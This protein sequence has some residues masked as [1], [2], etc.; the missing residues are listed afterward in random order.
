MNQKGKMYDVDLKN[1]SKNKKKKTIKQNQ[2]NIN[3]NIVQ[4]NSHDENSEDDLAS[5]QDPDVISTINKSL[6][7]QSNHI[8]NS[9]I[10]A[11]LNESEP[12]DIDSGNRSILSDNG[13]KGP[14]NSSVQNNP[15]VF[16]NQGSVVLSPNQS[17]Q[18]QQQKQQIFQEN[19]D[20]KQIQV[21]AYL[22]ESRD[23]Q[24]QK[25]EEIQGKID[26]Q[27]ILK[28]QILSSTQGQSQRGQHNYSQLSLQHANQVS[29]SFLSSPYN[30]NRNQIHQETVTLRF[31]CHHTSIHKYPDFW[32]ELCVEDK[33]K[34]FTK[35]P[36]KQVG[37]PYMDDIIYVD[38]PMNMNHWEGKNLVYRYVI[39]KFMQSETYY[40]KRHYSQFKD[41]RVFYDTPQV[42]YNKFKNKD[43]EPYLSIYYSLI[44]N[45]YNYGNKVH[46]NLEVLDQLLIFQKNLSYAIKLEVLFKQMQN[47]LLN[48]SCHEE[49]LKFCF[50]IV[51]FLHQKQPEIKNEAKMYH[52]PLCKTLNQMNLKIHERL[53]ISYL[54]RDLESFLKNELK[55]VEFMNQGLKTLTNVNPIFAINYISN[56]N[57]V[58]DPKEIF[59]LIVNL[60]E[61]PTT[62]SMLQ[63]VV[64]NQIYIRI[65]TELISFL[66]QKILQCARSLNDILIL[67]EYVLTH[68]KTEDLIEKIRIVKNAQ[69]KR[70]DLGYS[71]WIYTN[72]DCLLENSFLKPMFQEEIS[73]S[74]LGN[75]HKPEFIQRFGNVLKDHPDLINAAVIHDFAQNIYEYND[76]QK[77]KE[78]LFTNVNSRKPICFK[79]FCDIMQTLLRNRI[80][81]QTCIITIAQAFLAQ[82]EFHNYQIFQTNIVDF[83]ERV[84]IQKYCEQIAELLNSPKLK[85][86]VQ[87]LAQYF[88]CMTQFS[89]H[90]RHCL[91]S[92]NVVV[93]QSILNK[94]GDSDEIYKIVSQL[95]DKQ[96]HRLINE[97]LYPIVYNL[98]EEADN[99]FSQEEVEQLLQDVNFMK[100][101]SYGD[102]DSRFIMKLTSN[103]FQK[104]YNELKQGSFTIKSIKPFFTTQYFR[105]FQ[106]VFR[107]TVPEFENKVLVHIQESFKVFKLETDRYETFQLTLLDLSELVDSDLYNQHLEEFVKEFENVPIKLLN[108]QRDKK[109]FLSLKSI[110]I[111]YQ[112]KDSTVYNNLSRQYFS[113]EYINQ[114][115]TQQIN[116]QNLNQDMD[117]DISEVKLSVKKFDK[118]YYEK[119]LMKQLKQYITQLQNY[120]DKNLNFI[121]L[122]CWD[123]IKPNKIQQEV[124]IL[125][126][127]NPA[128]EEEQN[129]EIN[130][131]Q[132][133][134]HLQ[135]FTQMNSIIEKCQILT[136]IGFL[137]VYYKLQKSDKSQ[138]I[139]EQFV[140]FHNAISTKSLLEIS[141]KL[142]QV[143][144]LL[145]F[146]I[147]S[148]Q[149]DF[150]KLALLKGS[151]ELIEFCQKNE[152]IDYSDLNDGLDDD[153]LL[154][155]SIL[156]DMVQINRFCQDLIKGMLQNNKQKENTYSQF[157]TYIQETI[158]I[159]EQN[160][161]NFQFNLS[162]CIRDLQIIKTFC[163]TQ[164]NSQENTLKIVLQIMFDG[165]AEFKI[166]GERCKFQINYDRNKS[167]DND[168]I[169]QY[170]AR[171]ILLSHNKRSDD[172]EKDD[173]IKIAD[174]FAQ[175]VKIFQDIKKIITEL[176][177]NGHLNFQSQQYQQQ[178]EIP[179][180]N[181]EDLQEELNGLTSQLKS[182]KELL[183]DLRMEFYYMTMVPNSKI[184]YLSKYFVN[185]CNENLEFIESVFRFINPDIDVQ[186][187]IGRMPSINDDEEGNKETIK[188]CSK[189]LNEIFF[190]NQYKTEKMFYENGLNELRKKVMLLGE[191]Q[192][193]QVTRDIDNIKAI[194]SIFS[195]CK[196]YPQM[197]QLMFCNKKTKLYE[198]ECFIMRAILFPNDKN[199]Q[200]VFILSN[201]QKLQL[202]IQDDALK[203]LDQMKEL[204]Q[205]KNL[206]KYI[207]IILQT[208]S[209]NMNEFL[210]E[211][212]QG[213]PSFTPFI[214]EEIYL[215]RFF[216]CPNAHLITSQRAGLGKSTF[217]RNAIQQSNC[218]Y[219]NIPFQGDLSKDKIIKI[220]QRKLSWKHGSIGLHY[221]VNPSQGEDL[222]I[223]LFEL[224]IF[225]G[226]NDY[227]N[228]IYQFSDQITIFIEFSQDIRLNHEDKYFLN[229]IGNKKEL[230]WSL[231]RVIVNKQPNS[232]SQIVLKSIRLVNLQAFD[233]E[234]VN[235]E[236]EVIQDQEAQELLGDYY[237]NEISEP[238]FFMID[239][240]IAFAGDQLEQMR[241]SGFF[242]LAYFEAQFEDQAM[243]FLINFVEQMLLFSKNLCIMTRS[244]ANQKLSI[245]QNKVGQL[246]I[247]QGINEVNWSLQDSAF[248]T[249]NSDGT[250]T[251]IFRNPE[252]L[253]LSILA[254]YKILI[255]VM[256]QNQSDQSK[257]DDI[258]REVSSF[259]KL[260]QEQVVERIFKICGRDYK[261]FNQL[262]KKSVQRFDQFR[263][264]FTADNFLK[265][266]L[267]YLR[268]RSCQLVTIMGETG[269][270]KTALIEYLKD[271]LC[272]DY[273][274]LNIHEGV[275]EVQIKEFVLDAN[276]LQDKRV[277]LFFDEVN[278]NFNVSGL[279]KEI[280]VDRTVEGAK[281]GDHIRIVAA[282]NP[283]KL[284][285]EN[286]Q[287]NERRFTSGIKHYR[288]NQLADNVVYRVHPLPESVFPSV[289][290]YG[291]LKLEEQQ[292]YI[293]KII[294]RINKFTN[295]F[296]SDEMIQFISAI[297]FESHVFIQQK[298]TVSSVSLRDVDRFKKLFKYFY[299][300]NS[301]RD[302]PDFKIDEF[303]MM[304]RVLVLTMTVCYK[305]SLDSKELRKEYDERIL[306]VNVEGF[307]L[308]ASQLKYYLDDEEDRYI[309]KMEIPL[310]I[311][312]NDSLKENVFAI[313]TMIRNKI[314]LFITGKPGSSKTLAMNLV[315]KSMRGK[316]SQN[317]FF[318]RFPAIQQVNYQGSIQSTSSG[319]ERIF[320]R[321][322]KSYEEHE[323]KMKE[324]N[325][326]EPSVIIVVIIDEIGLA[327]LSPH[328]PLKVL[329][330]YLE[331]F[332]VGFVGIS[333]WSLDD[334][335]RNRGINLSKPEPND[336]DLIQSADSQ[337]SEI[338]CRDRTN[339]SYRQNN[340]R[341]NSQIYNHFKQ[342][343]LNKLVQFYQKYY[344]NQI[345]P[346]FHGLRDFYQLVCYV[347][348]R[349]KNQQN[350]YT[351][352][353]EGVQRNFGGQNMEKVMNYLK[354]EFVDEE[355]IQ[356][357]V[358]L[359]SS[360]LIQENLSDKL[361]RNLMIISD[362]QETITLRYI[363]QICKN[364]N[365]LFQV[366]YGSNFEK[367]KREEAIY[368]IINDIILCMESGT[369]V[370]LLNLDNI[371]Q[372]FYDML[373]QNYQI[374][375]GQ[376][377]CKV[378]IGSDSS[379][380]IVDDDFKC[381]LLVNSK[382]AKRMDAPLLN[383][384]EKHFYDD[385]SNLTRDQQ[386]LVED[387]TDWMDKS[388]N[389]MHFTSKDMYPVLTFN[390]KQLNNSL[391]SLVLQAENIQFEDNKEKEE[392]ILN[393]CKK[394]I[395][396][397]AN[398][399][400]VIRIRLTNE[401]YKD[402]LDQFYNEYECH[403]D[404]M[405]MLIRL[406]A[407]WK[408]NLDFN[409]QDL[410]FN[411]VVYTYSNITT[412]FEDYQQELSLYP[413]N[414]LI[415]GI[416]SKDQLEKQLA[417]YFNVDN[418]S[419][420]LIVIADSSKNNSIMI[421]SLCK[422]LINQQRNK[423][424]IYAQKVSQVTK[425]YL[426]PQKNVVFII[427]VYG[428][429]NANI[430]FGQGWKETFIDLSNGKAN[431][432]THV[433][434]FLNCTLSRL[435]RDPEMFKDI[436]EISIS[437][438]CCNQLYQVTHQQE[439]QFHHLLIG[440]LQF[441]R[442][443]RNERLLQLQGGI[444]N[445]A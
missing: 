4:N 115:K 189:Q 246:G 405:N 380:C 250:V 280:M 198:V 393:F 290:D 312:I 136:S 64:S 175:K 169:N 174:Q 348:Y 372:A 313:I 245:D 146:L 230:E 133:I 289:Q 137:G 142:S 421:I 116:Q 32:L 56:Q 60:A 149:I 217:I 160:D 389:V 219:V 187:L 22:K 237:L 41:Q 370:I 13:C 395:V 375:N 139:I 240:F 275:T 183:L 126:K 35:F 216:N 2:F 263:L 107:M 365:R 437:N 445:L 75:S 417:D 73:Q 416:L 318:K 70:D 20:T 243:E 40:I 242:S 202:Q 14:Y 199:E 27:V 351:S 69:F 177:L 384:F 120:P 159:H 16:E 5:D 283:Y 45:S 236:S 63:R 186:S 76:F 260:T 404:I 132:L 338:C 261:Q 121:D 178:Y 221:V 83:D 3:E 419:Q 97:G 270:G 231:D 434:K 311:G 427:R 330:A 214:V 296:Y 98:M 147:E 10:A 309:N 80:H 197:S 194:A 195:V 140:A 143:S 90:Q 347:S 124:D 58:K 30:M 337:F 326:K 141:V 43:S 435:L 323:K 211:Q 248:V 265:M 441:D 51:G 442:S 114:L 93:A 400:S 48:Q 61:D 71:Y 192:I 228:Q 295:V 188:Q 342:N 364:N 157:L 359:Q 247:I 86:I 332:K 113:Q 26:T 94:V 130:N 31:Y 430:C 266:N 284:K 105:N 210:I 293:N 257:I 171:A 345:T 391:T 292:I 208:V 336:D 305:L 88:N 151:S 298:S 317:D 420:N 128:N 426:P 163:D 12:M 371:Y 108:Q 164:V 255:Q 200:R 406:E 320:D 196:F 328:N 17:F 138:E 299:L 156:Q 205:T 104:M 65:E 42:F 438:A 341:N 238:N 241:K 172:I 431:T 72:L 282:C 390:Q 386:L 50:S 422:S 19:E 109:F 227:D 399:A 335:K 276:L 315:L 302:D 324:Q 443:I 134:Q 34:S 358:K 239:Q 412:G 440:R 57:V 118:I 29:Q 201:F 392:E 55:E 144:T 179:D 95:I 203:F 150:Q 213:K 354:A 379:K 224:L 402:Q 39:K 37:I 314:P 244:M 232:Y 349:M 414:I 303:E 123:N 286:Q 433:D 388:S 235:D 106:M 212:M 362:H 162:N 225:Q 87:Q 92:F 363:E 252:D 368:Q 153:T 67:D 267:I 33:D 353:A 373:N 111:D 285:I 355:E 398:H 6:V 204:A 176:S 79:D 23:M 11:D 233:W 167:I 432:Q 84:I 103:K 74:V 135:Q 18:Q 415:D 117:Q 7:N 8:P 207:L 350:A 397:L 190:K 9:N 327:E 308:R 184:Q 81:M 249:F 170:S 357:Y 158:S 271:V 287:Q 382:D 423:Y 78:Y 28:E 145:N 321:A 281:F 385:F 182:W 429:F 1:K 209:E 68:L 152:N 185:P 369:I 62:F 325:I 316:S 304:M 180:C 66:S 424:K 102:Q 129:I 340:K 181:I 127:N 378:A 49:F 25:R 254:Y 259:E 168:K 396:S 331:M 339:Q 218:Q 229:L 439:Y 410:G 44:L 346:N 215:K 222:N 99:Y 264:A 206:K 279:L 96:S 24:A 381:I 165:Q 288:I 59:I 413:K 366:F 21:N 334:S 291:A 112:F 329:H 256:T 53:D 343:I 360:H 307:H 173:N 125:F 268:L 383:R 15:Q 278:T 220:H 387:L 322:Y 394:Q 46:G 294:Q 418:K 374:L 191:V 444:N 251:P 333:N 148:Y 277:I 38:I 310:G 356:N 401:S 54:R 408:E 161:K 226:I 411:V 300:D 376:K 361:A 77:I 297:V 258:V 403:T 428:V 352:I 154:D 85:D 47:T 119:F 52:L 301:A 273:R 274:K 425:G 262:P 166:E 223:I 36:M 409:E 110:A 269:V 100:M 155:N 272:W 91:E 234:Y 344:N 89:T 253:P 367:D 193:Y 407:N 319:I 122:S 377:R 131:C 436:L 306:Q 101:I 82:L